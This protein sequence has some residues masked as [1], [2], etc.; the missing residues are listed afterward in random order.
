MWHAWIALLT[1]LA[2]RAYAN[3]G[4]YNL[5]CR[6]AAWQTW[7]AK[8]ECGSIGGRDDALLVRDDGGWSHAYFELIMSPGA[9]YSISGALYAEEQGECDSSSKALWCSPSVNVCPGKHYEHFND[10]GCVAAFAPK[11]VGVWEAFMEYFTATEPTMTVYINQEST[12]FDSWSSEL[13]VTRFMWSRN[14]VQQKFNIPVN[15]TL[16]MPFVLALVC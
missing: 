3:S 10:G 9:V 14:T 4:V 13:T 5:T 8:V 1:S 12:T 6:N 11:G 15:V 7:N 2:A 16:G